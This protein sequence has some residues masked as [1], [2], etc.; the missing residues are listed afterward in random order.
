MSAKVVNKIQKK[1]TDVKIFVMGLF[2]RLFKEVRGWHGG[3]EEP[4]QE[5]LPTSPKAPPDLPKGEETM[6][7]RGPT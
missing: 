7:K 2:L 4:L 5:P 3:K 1:K 6:R